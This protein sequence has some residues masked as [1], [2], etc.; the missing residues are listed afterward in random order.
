[1]GGE[2][3]L[4][5]IQKISLDIMIRVDE[6]CDAHDFRYYLYGGS[7]LGAVRHKGFIPWDDDID[8]VM[9]RDDYERFIEFM[10]SHVD[11]IKPLRLFTYHNTADY[12]YMISRVSNDDYYLKVENE[13][14][15]G[16]GIFI[17]VYPWDGIGNSEKEIAKR[18]GV[19]SGLSSLCYLSTR[20]RCIKENTKSRTR[21]LVKPIAFLASKVIGKRLFMHWLERMAKKYSYDQTEYVGCLVWGCDG[22]KGIFLRSWMGESICKKEFEGHLFRVP[23]ECEKALTRLYKDYMRLPS[24]EEQVPHHHYTAYRRESHG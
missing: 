19:A 9:P 15:Y 24:K 8:I 14:P 12:P 4:R 6:I 5:E 23:E 18:K 2:L 7:L 17:D 10:E 3:S 16:I 11:E 22:I 13:E 21:M 1:M 20:R